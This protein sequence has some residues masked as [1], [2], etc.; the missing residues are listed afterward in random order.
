MPDKETITYTA[1]RKSTKTSPGA[2]LD[3]ASLIK[4]DRK[5]SNTVCL[6]LLATYAR[7]LG[8]PDPKLSWQAQLMFHEAQIARDG[9]GTMGHELGY[10]LKSFLEQAENKV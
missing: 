1:H 9:G 4:K 8:L 10:Q 6:S 2:Y 3:I 5:N 7:C